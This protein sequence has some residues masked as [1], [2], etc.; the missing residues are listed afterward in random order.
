M[1]IIQYALSA[2]PHVITVGRV[3]IMGA[4]EQD[5]GKVAAE[6]SWPK[7]SDERKESTKKTNLFSIK[8]SGINN[9]DSD[10]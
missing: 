9:T 1:V 5:C 8:H 4:A 6:N 10:R 2:E 3:I 7:S